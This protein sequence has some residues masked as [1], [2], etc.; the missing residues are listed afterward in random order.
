MSHL[1]C[2]RP[3]RRSL[4]LLLPLLLMA[5][6]T[7]AAAEDAAGTDRIWSGSGELGLALARGNS[8]SESVNA[9]IALSRQ[10]EHWTRSFHGSLLR[11]RGEVSGDFDGDGVVERRYQASANRYELGGASAY[12]FD[13][14]NS[15]VA[16]IRYENDD[17]AASDYQA[18]VSVGYG[19]TFVDGKRT[20]LKT[21][22]GPGFRSAREAATGVTDHSTVARGQLNFKH[23]LTDNS[24]LYDNLLMEAGADNTFLQNDIGV[25]VS[26]NSK[27]ALKVGMQARHNSKVEPGRKRT[28]TLTTVN[29][30][31]RIR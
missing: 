16:T 31:Y 21:E 18:I 25:A 1:R 15:I 30:V 8:R 3:F 17:F 28:D 6:P 26:M 4:P 29:L 20:S 9:K 27:L 12:R 10:T 5:T 7:A 14:R 19:H 13:P 2:L 24:S 23:Q 22:I 11:A